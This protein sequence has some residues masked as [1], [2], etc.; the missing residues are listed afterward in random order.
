VVQLHPHPLR[1]RGLSSFPFCKPRSLLLNKSARQVVVVRNKPYIEVMRNPIITT[2][3]GEVM[4]FNDGNLMSLDTN[5]E[6]ITEWWYSPEW[7]AL[8]LSYG[9]KA[10]YYRGVP[11][12]VIHEML[13]VDSL[14]KFANLVIKPNYEVQEAVK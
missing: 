10:Y 3:T 2:P 13:C 8:K 14:G 1:A 11:Y 4:L 12:S 9:D 5:S 6:I 7:Q